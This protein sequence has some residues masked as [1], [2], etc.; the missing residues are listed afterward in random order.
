MGRPN[1]PAYRGAGPYVFVS[2]AHLD[3]DDVYGEIEWLN[4]SGFDI[5]Y[6]EGIEPG[7]RWSDELA[8]A[9]AN[10][11]CFLAFISG[12][13]VNSQNCLNEIEFALNRGVQ[14]I[15]VHLEE[16]ALPPGLELGLGSRQGILKFQMALQDYR[17]KLLDVLELG[18]ESNTAAP[19]PGSSAVHGSVPA[20]KPQK[21][22]L[23]AVLALSIAVLGATLAWQWR[24]GRASQRISDVHRRAAVPRQRCGPGLPVSL[25]RHR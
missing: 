17:R 10:C 6:D 8:T 19:L 22:W 24:Q 12:A 11:R 7:T 4:A 3:A 23:T 1:I 16:T 21:N 18:T 14:V 20:R 5:W 15:A 2:Y 13:A 25:R 9:I